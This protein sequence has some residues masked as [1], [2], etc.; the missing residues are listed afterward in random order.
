MSEE[1]P[2]RSIAVVG[3]GIVALSAALAFARALP[4]VRV[5]LV[6][7]PPDPLALIDRLTGTLPPVGRFHAAIGLDE[8]EL[9]RSGAA[10]H[11]IGTRFERWSASGEPWYHVFGSYGLATGAVPFH[12]IWL[13]ARRAGEA[14]PYHR[15]A[16]AAVLAEADRFVHPD[17][18]PDR[19]LS[20][21]I[22][23]LRLDP[24]RYLERL[25]REAEAR[26]LP[27][28]GATVAGV[29]HRADGGIAALVLNGGQRVEADLF[30]DCAG[31]GAPLLGAL[32]DGYED[33]SGFLPCDRVLFGAKASSAPP[34]PVDVATAT[35][36]GWRWSAPL[37]DRVETGLVFASAM[38]SD[39]RASRILAAETGA[40][41]G[42]AVALRPGRR[43]EPWVRNVL[44]L[45]DAAISIDPLQS[46]NLYL[47]Q[48][49]ILLALELLPGR[50]C[51]PLELREYN[52]RAALE[53]E[54]VRDFVAVHYLKSGRSQGDFWKEAARRPVPD[55]LATTIEQF[56]RRG[57][58]PFFEEETFDKESWQAVLLG[59][60]ALPKAVAPIATGVDAVRARD[61]MARLAQGLAE[62]PERLPDYPSYL[63]RMREAGGH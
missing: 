8:L 34:S 29:E 38:T 36:A 40:E 43:P 48:S 56:E 16:A 10:V 59:M 55:S 6:E 41:A 18:R 24:M 60:G 5:G 15:Y 47:A 17:Q 42:E 54:R 31:P 9:V 1:R 58:I 44:A 51:H 27:R 28:I 23:A 32:S 22:Y 53:A 37:P 3:G 62:L 21:F 39:G 52:R 7:T 35:G 19:P 33:W 46:T 2:I 20:T 49:A 30:V 50:D 11:R 26:R 57:R 25:R 12:Q 63:R 4:Q 45:G 61:A 14:L 13:R